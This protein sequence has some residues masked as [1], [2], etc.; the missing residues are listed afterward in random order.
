MVIDTSYTISA[1]GN[2]SD[3]IPTAETMQF[4]LNSFGK[5]DLIPS[6]FQEYQIEADIQKAMP[7]QRVSLISSDNKEQVTI[8]SNR[9][10][11][12][13]MV[14]DD[15][16]LDAQYRDG[17][18][19]K[20]CNI[21]ETIFKYFKKQ[22]TRLALNAESLVVDIS[23]EEVSDFMSKY[24]NPIAIFNENQMFEWSTRLVVKE[25]RPINGQKETINII[26]VIAKTMINKVE[27]DQTTNLDGFKINIDI[28]TIAENELSRFSKPDIEDFVKISTGLWD[29]IIEEMG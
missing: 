11:Y 24:S 16:K 10:D 18:N 1:F 5:K 7:V 19:Q 14:N 13:V 12:Q 27:E 29:N 6:V 23:P 3:V 17:I 20:V 9:I 25:S 28:N 8:S 15:T 4:F 21:Y 2:F 22:S 26:A